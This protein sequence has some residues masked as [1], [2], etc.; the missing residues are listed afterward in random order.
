[1]K[2][3]IKIALVL[4]SLL[5]VIFVG[6][7]GQ[8]TGDFR[9][10]PHVPNLPQEKL[11]IQSAF[12]N[13]TENSIILTVKSTKENITLNNAIIKDSNGD[14]LASPTSISYSILEGETKNLIV[15]S[16]LSSGSYTILLITPRGSSFVSPSFNVS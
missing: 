6:Y 16:T 10:E 12:Y 2:K 5:T 1:M 14:A 13:S 11:A 7:I 8:Y 15:N 4:L 9:N 3:S